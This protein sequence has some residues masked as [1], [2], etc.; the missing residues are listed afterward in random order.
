MYYV[1]AFH[2]MEITSIVILAIHIL[3]CYL[4]LGSGFLRYGYDYSYFLFNGSSI[5]PSHTLFPIYSKC[6]LNVLNPDGNLEVSK[7]YYQLQI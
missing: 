1:G 2:I 7:K 4:L 6:T 5:D 3:I